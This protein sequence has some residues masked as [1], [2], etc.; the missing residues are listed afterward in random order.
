MACKGPV[1]G[2]NQALYTGDYLMAGE[3]LFVALMQSDG[4]LV[5]YP[6]MNAI[7]KP[8]GAEQGS[9]WASN[10]YSDTGQCVALMQSD[11]NFVIYPTS[12]AVG[13]DPTQQSG[14]IWATN[15]SGSGG[16]FS[17]YLDRRGVLW[18]MSG[19]PGPGGNAS[20]LWQTGGPNALSE[21][22]H[23]SSNQW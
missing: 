14:A 3:G 6:G 1:L 4:N 16:Q 9:I 20:V 7:G 8:P 19:S 15:T 23:Q 21:F 2:T 10:S 11:G 18:V 13:K 5:V 22:E 17:V 12:D